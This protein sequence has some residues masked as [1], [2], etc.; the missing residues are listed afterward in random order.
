M[1]CLKLMTAILG[2]ASNVLSKKKKL[3][4][5]GKLTKSALSNINNILALSQNRV[6]AQFMFT[7][8]MSN[9]FLHNCMSLKA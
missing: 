3:R 4:I 7:D 2:T 1:P 8:L 6:T 9:L 5:V